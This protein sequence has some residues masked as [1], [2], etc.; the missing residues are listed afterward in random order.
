MT[1]VPRYVTE[2]QRDD[3]LEV[4]KRFS[5]ANPDLTPR[6]PNIHTLGGLLTSKP[7]A[8]YGYRDSQRRWGELFGLSLMDHLDFFW[9]SPTQRYVC[10]SM[11]YLKIN[12][13]SIER[14]LQ[15]TQMECERVSRVHQE[16]SVGKK[17]PGEKLIVHVGEDDTSWYIPGYPLVVLASSRIAINMSF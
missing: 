2:S 9:H 14:A 15:E 11:P 10:A 13:G 7:G 16:S 3:A 6:E 1:N 5:V 4:Y 17:Y 8:R 12:G